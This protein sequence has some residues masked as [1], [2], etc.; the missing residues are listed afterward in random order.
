[1]EV[2]LS[3]RT[4]DGARVVLDRRDSFQWVRVLRVVHLES[5]LVPVDG[6]GKVVPRDFVERRLEQPNTVVR[7]DAEYSSAGSDTAELDWV[8]CTS[9]RRRSVQLGG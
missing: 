5:E 2:S 4:F 6:D 1:M 7:A 3:V 9:D 8:P